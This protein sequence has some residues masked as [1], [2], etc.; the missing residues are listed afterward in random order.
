MHHA[1]RHLDR[2]ARRAALVG[3]LRAAVVE[4]DRPVVQRTGHAG[5]EHDALAQRTA[6]VRAAVEQREDLVLGI[7]EHR[8]VDTRGTGHAPRTQHGDVVDAA[9]GFPFVHG[10]ALP[11]FQTVCASLSTTATGVNCRTSTEAWLDS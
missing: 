4:P 1:L 5:A 3:R 9:D 7:A 6:L 11:F 2:E 8:D 10:R